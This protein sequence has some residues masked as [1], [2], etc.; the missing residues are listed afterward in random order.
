MWALY[1]HIKHHCTRSL[2][3]RT[4]ASRNVIVFVLAIASL[5]SVQNQ[6]SVDRSVSIKN[7]AKK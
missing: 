4:Q 6:L 2:M 1:D 7:V 5:R 3:S